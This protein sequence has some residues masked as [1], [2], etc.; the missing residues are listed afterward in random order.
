M[1]KIIVTYDL[2]GEGK[3]YDGLIDRLKQYPTH[4]KINKSSWLIKT[5]YSC[6]EVRNEL[7]KQIDGDDMLFVAKLAGEAAWTKAESN[8]SDIKKALESN[9]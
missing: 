3:N 2:C 5:I 1:N 9:D 7:M 6:A 4:L 8:N